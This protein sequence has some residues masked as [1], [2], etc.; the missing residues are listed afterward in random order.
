MIFGADV[1]SAP[2]Q[3]LRRAVTETAAAARKGFARFM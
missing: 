2:P 3:A 1:E